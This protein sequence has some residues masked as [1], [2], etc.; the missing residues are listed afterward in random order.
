M[1]GTDN[2]RIKAA[3]SFWRCLRAVGRQTRTPKV[4]PE[5]SRTRCRHNTAFLGQAVHCTDLKDSMAGPRWQCLAP[6]DCAKR[7]WQQLGFWL[8]CS[9]GKVFSCRKTVQ[10]KSACRW[11]G[12]FCFTDLHFAYLAQ[13]PVCYRKPLESTLWKCISPNTGDTAAVLQNPLAH[14][15][16]GPSTPMTVP[17]QS[18]GMTDGPET[19]WKGNCGSALVLLK[20][21]QTHCTAVENCLFPPSPVS[22]TGFWVLCQPH[23][24][25]QV[26]PK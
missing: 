15:C 12:K 16:R 26:F 17:I 5:A 7:G 24:S 19:S 3:A 23:F 8:F 13:R 6:P 25:L 14:L 2:W 9:T 18:P 1:G 22:P 4:S 21:F 11:K 20:L 10:A